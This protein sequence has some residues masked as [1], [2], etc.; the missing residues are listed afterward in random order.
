MKLV[1]VILAFN[2]EMHLRRCIE[3]LRGCVDGILV[4]DSFSTDGTTKIAEEMGARVLSHAFHNYATQFNWAL[5][6]VDA[7]TDWVLRID[8]D[9]VL[10]PELA[11]EMRDRMGALPPNVAGIYIN[12]WMVFLGRSIRWGGVYP[13]RVLRIWRHGLGHCENRWMDEHVKVDGDTVVFPGGIR[14][15]NLNSLV[16][17]TAKHNW[18]SSREAVDLLNLKWRFQPFETVASLGSGA[19][20]KRWVKENI[21][22]RLPGGARAF[23]YFFYRY[24]LALGFLDGKPGLAFHFLQGF[25]YRYLVDAKVDEVENYIKRHDVAMEE[26][27]YRVLGIEVKPPGNR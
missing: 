16:W 11:R 26:A 20:V 3:S 18:Y 8:A 15:E 12:R 5:E 4:V 10:T 17:W 23:A 27:I 24:V 22:A 2:E 21:Y 25:W 1:A 7:D 9:E 14:D 6:H 13:I 19:G